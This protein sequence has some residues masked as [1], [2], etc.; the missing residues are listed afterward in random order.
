MPAPSDLDL[1]VPVPDDRRLAAAP[2]DTDL[3]RL[4]AR[5]RT[6]ARVRANMVASVDGAATGGDGRSA[7]LGTPADRRVFA[8]LRALADVVLVG[9]G[10]VR[11]E[12]YRE[13]PVAE[14]LRSARAAA[15]LPSRIAL[16]VVTRR[17]EVP[18]DLLAG[19]QLPFVVTGAAGADRARAAVGADRAVVVPGAHEADSPDL[20]A[21]VHALAARGLRH[22]LAEG[23]PRLLA[24]LLAA[25]V[26]D[27]L[28]LTTSPLLVAGDAP[29]PAA[30]AAALDPARRAHLRH[31]LHAAD[32]TL[33]ACW[34]LRAPVGS[35]S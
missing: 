14:H 6:C 18:A 1:L 22:V 30:G 25:G 9:A 33:L 24:A 12:G 31:L 13:L 20:R 19:P 11:A 10:T 15:G 34:D 4:F 5:D 21:G 23:G 29:R 17:G 35:G 26:V 7:S 8:V 3:L 32:G 2:D 28:C 16:A 27:E